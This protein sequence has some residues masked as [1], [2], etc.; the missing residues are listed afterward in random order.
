MLKPI[1]ALA[2]IV[3]AA[4]PVIA[5]QQPDVMAPVRQFI[6]GFNKGDV[7]MAQA[8]CADQTFI[9]DDFPPHE[10]S[11]RGATSKG[12]H[13]LARMG[14]KNGMS[15]PWSLCASPARSTSQGVIHM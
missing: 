9:V 14:K 3:V 4:D 11:E 10:W 1:I 6:S 13:D 8:D 12:F 7:K 2:V 5:S 15:E